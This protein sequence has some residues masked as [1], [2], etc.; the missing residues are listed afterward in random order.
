METSVSY[1]SLLRVAGVGFF[2]LGFIA[3][4][5]YATSALATLI[6]FQAATYSY[7][8]AGL[9]CAAQSIAVAVGGTLVGVL[10]DRY[11]HQP[12]GV[13]AG[14]ADFGAWAALLAASHGTLRTRVRRVRDRQRSGRRRLRLTDGP[15]GTAAGQD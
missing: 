10:A 13:A 9:A 12:V 2:P 6:P 14:I 3:R 5:P 7:A 1:R 15:L 11:G 4:L 8:L